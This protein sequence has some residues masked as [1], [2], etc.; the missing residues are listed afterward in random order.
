MNNLLI[1]LSQVDGG[2]GNWTAS[3]N[4]S[5]ACGD[6]Y[7][8]VSRKC[9]SPAPKYGGKNCSGNSTMTKTCRLKYCPG[10]ILIF[11]QIPP[12]LL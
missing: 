10:M 4:C 12:A 9:D 2:Y 11:Q 6:G 8:N 1:Y 3:S 7:Y 5:V